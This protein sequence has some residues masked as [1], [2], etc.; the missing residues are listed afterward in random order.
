VYFDRSSGLGDAGGYAGE[1]VA[2]SNLAGRTLADLVL[3][4]ETERTALPWVGHRSRQWEPEPLR[5]IGAN[6][7]TSLA[8][9]ADRAEI[10]SGRPSRVLDGAFRLLTGR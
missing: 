10:R 5:W 6:L 9:A 8:R 4:R 1:G 3:G 2:A 7:A